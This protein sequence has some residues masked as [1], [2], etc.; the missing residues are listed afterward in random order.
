MQ[1]REED[2]QINERAET[3]LQQNSTI[4]TV[5]VRY[6]I[7]YLYEGDYLHLVGEVRNVWNA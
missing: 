7:L 6:P 4:P 5:V 1:K 3:Y 2:K